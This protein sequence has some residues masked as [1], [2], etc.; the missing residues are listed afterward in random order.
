MASEVCPAMID[1][2]CEKLSQ[3]WRSFDLLKSNDWICYD[4]APQQLF[5][6]HH[7]W[8]YFPH[9][10]DNCPLITGIHRPTPLWII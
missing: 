1:M 7:T 6:I 2:L 5:N 4:P 9:Y 10:L 8:L 3:L